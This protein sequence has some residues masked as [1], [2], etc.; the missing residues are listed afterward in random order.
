MTRVVTVR[1]PCRLHFGMFSFGHADRPQFGGVGVMMDPPAVELSIMPASHFQV[2]GSHRERV[3]QFAERAAARWGLPNL[4]ACR[5]HIR[6]P[7]DHI[8]LGVGTQL[9]L[10][11]AAAL[12]RFL[13]LPDLPVETLAVDMHRGNRSA[14][15]THGFQ[16]GGLI[17]DEGHCGGASVGRLVTR[18]TVPETW[19][20]VLVTPQAQRGLAGACESHA[21]TRLPP[22]PDEVTRELW[23][24]T[25]H[26]MLPALERG[27]CGEF[28]DAVYRYGRLAGECFSAVQGGPFASREIADLIAA[29][30]DYGVPGVGQSSWGPT[31][32]AVCASLDAA[33]AL[34]ECLRRKSNT[35]TCDVEYATPCNT[36]ARVAVQDD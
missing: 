7:R 20:F 27:D 10:S 25:E 33:T 13:N 17:V 26:D 36:G 31:V 16:H 5:V 23:Y 15:G 8:G 29:I 14:V 30:R 35:Q 4:P 22:V 24:I 3:I 28:G 12:R 19:R 6:A 34:I 2:A 32:F 1:A 18:R 21:F 11:V 9:G